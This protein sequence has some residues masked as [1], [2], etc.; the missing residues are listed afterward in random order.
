MPDVGDGVVVQ[1]LRDSVMFVDGWSGLGGRLVEM[2]LVAACGEE[3][4]V[5]GG[6]GSSEQGS[7]WLT[8]EDPVD[9]GSGSQLGCTSA[10]ACR[11][12]TV[13]EQRWS[14]AGAWVRKWWKGKSFGPACV[15]YSRAM[16]L[17]KAA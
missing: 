13:A 7:V 9:D 5:A 14:G 16:Q 3:G 8:V 17:E 2:A 6:P 1:G 11:R 10:T 12:T 4:G 15:L